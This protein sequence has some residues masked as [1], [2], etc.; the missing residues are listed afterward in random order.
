MFALKKVGGEEES[1]DIEEIFRDTS[2][3]NTK[4]GY[5]MKPIKQR[6]QTCEINCIILCLYNNWMTK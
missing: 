4:F 2:I 5:P 1:F 3:K 6:G